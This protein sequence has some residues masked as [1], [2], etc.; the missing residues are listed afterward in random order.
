M[1]IKVIE[2][3][4]YEVA[5]IRRTG[6][7]FEHQG[8]W[9]Q[10][11]RWA[12]ENQ[13]YPPQQSF[14]GISL[15]NPQM[16]EGKDCRHDACVT[17]PEGFPKEHHPDR[18]FKRLEEGSYALYKFYDKPEKLSSAYSELYEQWL[19]NSLYIADEDRVPLEFNMNNPAEDPEGKCK[20]DLYI[21]VRK[22][23]AQ[24]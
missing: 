16:V 10:L 22:N 1:E 8:H 20:V 12:F 18:Q 19:P 6:S 14:I 11:L 13:L 3:P 2:L 5:Y 7:Y 17:I 21:P 24:L 15:D 9:D 4:A 23:K